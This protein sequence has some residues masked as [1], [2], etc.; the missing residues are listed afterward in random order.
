MLMDW[1][2]SR[3]FRSRYFRHVRETFDRLLADHCVRERYDVDSLRM[4]VFSD[5]HRGD[6]TGADDFA[7]CEDTYLGALGH[8]FGEGYKLVLLGDVEELWEATPKAAVACYE[9]P[10]MAER[11]FADAGRYIRV[12]GNHDDA[13]S[14][15]DQVRAY[16]REW[17]GEY[18]VQE[19]VA[20]S[21]TDG[22]EEI[23]RIFLAH[24]H[25]GTWD[26]DRAAAFSRFVVRWIW[27]PVQRFFRI[28]LEKTPS[29]DFSLRFKHEVAMHEWAQEQERLLLV[30]GHT[31]HPVF[32]SHSHE[33]RLEGE[34]AQ[35]GAR[36]A[37]EDSLEPA[38][39]E[40][41][42]EELEGARRSLEIKLAG[43]EGEMV[44][45]PVS[46][47]PCYFNAGCCSYPDGDITGLELAD[48]EIRLVRWH[49][50]IGRLA[51]PEVL[52]RAKLR[53]VFSECRSSDSP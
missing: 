9:E 49:L 46:V 42:E 28:S 15:P 12:W 2:V 38:V 23:G 48:G 25:Q 44:D 8:Y 32:C 37:S 10:L 35:L 7:P 45:R 20:V 36:I 6:R 5:H 1:V 31:H 34:I 21:V 19:A 50:E 24:G 11:R 41:L 30:T 52:C 40:R 47:K 14:F 39:R 16:L 43:Q 33:S 51:E 3:V 27:R 13:W 29:R 18:Q 26:S 22:G 17:I 53:E 4:V